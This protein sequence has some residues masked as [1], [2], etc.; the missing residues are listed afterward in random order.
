MSYKLHRV[1]M[2]E[3]AAKDLVKSMH[4]RRP[5]NLKLSGGNLSA[6]D[7]PLLL[8]AAQARHMDR[9]KGKNSGMM[10]KLSKRQLSELARMSSTLDPADAGLNKV[11]SGLFGDIGN[12]L[13]GAAKPFAS[14]LASSY[15][16]PV[17][18]PML[19]DALGSLA[20][21]AVSSIDKAIDKKKGK[22]GKGAVWGGT[23]PD[24][25]P[26]HTIGD[27]YGNDSSADAAPG[28]LDDAQPTDQT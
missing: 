15:A 18:G 12:F 9:A 19:T 23:Y 27:D 20:E 2:S 1:G 24:D 8:T 11:A 26:N 6:V 13:L 14:A 28:G 10:V 25:M 5:Y 4:D 7:Y 3:K 21:S 17:A 22:K 16:G